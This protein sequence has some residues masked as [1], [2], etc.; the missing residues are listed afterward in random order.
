[1]KPILYGALATA[2]LLASCTGSDK[3]ETKKEDIVLLNRDT[4]VNPADD[5]F[6]Y[7]VA[8]WTKKN[9]IPAEESS[10]GIAHLVQNELYARL[11]KINEDAEKKNAKSGTDQQI[12][13]F[14]HSGMDSANINKQGIEPLREEMNK[15]NAMQT[16]KDVMAM[17]ARMHT[18]GVGVFYGE[19]VS[20]D[21]K[22]SDV[23]AYYMSQGGI[24]L[25]NR[26]YYFNTDERTTKIRNEY[27]NYISRV[28]QLMG[29]DSTTAKTKATAIVA[30]EKQ[31]ASQSRKLE[32]LRDPYANYNKMAI[33]DLQKKLSPNIE[34]PSYLQQMGVK[35]VDSVIIGQPEFF[36]QLDKVVAS[37]N[38]QTLKDYMTF[39]LVRTFASYL[40]QPFFDNHFNFYNKLIRGAEQPR[41]RWKRV[42]D[43]EEGAM[44]EALGQLFAKEY[45]NE[46]AKKRY[47]NMVENVRTAYKARI[48]KLDWMTDST[49]Q[50][51][52]VKLAAITKKVGY[53]NKWKD[54]SALKI[55]RNSYVMNALHANEWWNNYEMNKLGKPVDREEWEM[56]PQTYNAYYNP[57][58][59]EIVLPAGIFTVPGY[60]DE[61]LDDA[62]VYG[63][64]AAS[65]I[66]HEITHGFDDEGRQFDAKGNLQNWWTA[67]DEEEFKK[68]A[69][70]LVKQFNNMV[71]V[72]TQHINGR[73]TLGENL[74][75]LG[76]L[77]IGLDAFKQT[78]AY[79]KGEMINGYTPLQR[80]FLGYALGWMYQIR[81]EQL[82]SQ[83]LTDVHSPAKFRVN[84]PLPN[85]P[86]FYEA[87][88]VKPGNKLYLP[89]SLRV[90]LW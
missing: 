22:A 32:A 70:V 55:D 76:G 30:M 43:A 44:G 82:A 6:E 21:A 59:N 26:D 24:G 75:D 61:E 47:E 77:L 46:T 31:L 90:R 17:A 63:Y 72:D 38:I 56:T 11:R 12:G 19:G 54:F 85:I 89:D 4:T 2:T 69:E 65:T 1:M 74:A 7:A 5:F 41:P 14:W 66:G 25:P 88:N 81:K 29:V 78:E 23:M 58:N 13:D 71:P 60:R 87:F 8:G 64:A 37:E 79:K 3:K 51:A 39:H 18:Y 9:P 27:P 53:P 67:K 16:P 50:K 52:L 28:F 62:L 48:E 73:A 57:S 33:S 10:W 84:G 40:S 36:K 45:F 80:Y 83:L 35:H 49:K 15:I 20:Q 68:R 34:W 42:L 86:E